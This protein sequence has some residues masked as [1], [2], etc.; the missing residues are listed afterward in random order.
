VNPYYL[1]LTTVTLAS[2]YGLLALGISIIWSS[3]GMI[4]MAQG[5]TF[6]VSGYGAWLVSQDLSQDGFAVV[7]G[8]VITGALAGALIGGVAFIPLYDK[9]NFPLRSLIATLA[10]SLLGAQGL[11][12]LF[13]PRVKALPK[14]FGRGSFHLG[15]VVASHEKV[16]SIVCSAVLLL[17]T[18]AWMKRSRRGLEIRAMMQNPEGAALVGVGLRST[19][20]AVMMVTGAMAG[21]AAVLLSQNYFVSPYSGTTPLIKGMVVALAGGL[22]SVSGALIAAVLI[23]FIEAVTAVSLGG[24]YVLITQFL[25]IIAVLLVRPRGIAGM[26]EHTRE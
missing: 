5:F 12:W 18:L 7:A 6:A 22:G 13:G 8:G 21:L 3:L 24:Q 10:I 1:A 19:A 20:M 26:I 4:N 2:I 11:L 17:A 15:T 25:F 9:P 23:G 16:G 14:I